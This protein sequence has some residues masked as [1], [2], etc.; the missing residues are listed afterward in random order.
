MIDFSAVKKI[1]IP[2]GAVKKITDSTGAVL[3]Q[4]DITFKIKTTLAVFTI[5][6]PSGSTWSDAAQIYNQSANSTN[7]YK[8]IVSRDMIMGDSVKIEY[9][10]GGARSATVSGAYPDDLIVADKTY[11]AT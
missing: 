10:S 1:V 4:G 3:W 9:Y 6:V 11:N 7:P 8:I 5:T 2:E